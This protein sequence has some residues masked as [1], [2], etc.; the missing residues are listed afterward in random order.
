MMR[1]FALLL[2][3]VAAGSAWGQNASTSPATGCNARN[4]AQAAPAYLAVND[5]CLGSAAAKGDGQIAPSTYSMK[6]GAP[7]LYLN[8]TAQMLV[9]VTDST[10]NGT[11]TISPCIARS[12]WISTTSGT[13]Y[14]IL[15]FGAGA[16]S[17]VSASANSSG[18]NTVTVASGGTNVPIY[19]PVTDTTTPGN[20][21]A[22]TYVTATTATSL[23]LNNNVTVASA[24]IV[25]Y[26][27]TLN[28]Q[29]NSP[30]S[31]CTITISPNPTTAVAGNLQY[32]VLFP[33]GNNGTSATTAISATWNQWRYDQC[34]ISQ[35]TA[36]LVCPAGTFYSLRDLTEGISQNSRTP[37]RTVVAIHDPTGGCA[38]QYAQ[39]LSSDAGGDT[40]TLDRP[41]A[42]AITAANY[43]SIYWGS[44]LF[45]S[46]YR[47]SLTM[48]PGMAIDVP[49]TGTASTGPAPV[50]LLTSVA[51][52][53]DYLSA[54]LTANA[55]ANTPTNPY[56][57]WLRVGTDDTA[58]TLAACA[59]AVSKFGG[60]RGCYWP[61]GINTF[62]ASVGT[63][64]DAVDAFAATQECGEGNIIWPISADWRRH[65]FDCANGPQPYDERM[66]F[67]AQDLR[68]SQ[69]AAAAG[70]VN[71]AIVG[72]SW[73][74][75]GINAITDASNIDGLFRSIVSRQNRAVTVVIDNFTIGGQQTAA[76]DPNGPSYGNGS[77]LPSGSPANFPDFYQTNTAAQWITYP[78]NDANK[79]DLIVSRLGGNDAYSF[80][81]GSFEN[82]INFTQSAAWYTQN[83]KYPDIRIVL[84]GSIPQGATTLAVWRGA[85]LVAGAQRSMLDSGWFNQVMQTSATISYLD[86]DA[87]EH[88]LAEAWDPFD[89]PSRYAMEILPPAPGNFTGS[90]QG[91][92]WYG[93]EPVM[94]FAAGITISQSGS[95]SAA[96]FFSNI[97]NGFC[98]GEGNGAATTPWLAGTQTGAHVPFSGGAIC[99]DYNTGSGNYNINRYLYRTV[100]TNTCALANGG[101]ATLT[102]STA[103]I[104]MG[105]KRGQAY[106]AGAGAAACPAFMGGGST[107]WAG[108]I[109]AGGVSSDGTTVTF[110]ATATTPFSSQPTTV[111]FYRLQPG[112]PVTTGGGLGAA[113][114]GP[115]VVAGGNTTLTFYIYAS[116]DGSAGFSE[117]VNSQFEEGTYRCQWTGKYSGFIEDQYYPSLF[118]EDNI[119]HTVM[120]I[121]TGPASEVNAW[122]QVTQ[123]SRLAAQFTTS[124]EGGPCP[125]YSGF[126]GGACYNHP[127]SIGTLGIYKRVF[128]NADWNF[129]PPQFSS[130]GTSAVSIASGACGAGANGTIS[131]VARAGKITIASAT[132]TACAVGFTPQWPTTLKTCTISPATSAS[133]GS[134]VAAYVS[135]LAA[136]GFTVSGT[137]LASTSFYYNC[138]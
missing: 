138:Q 132:T 55:A 44:S 3:L 113:G 74:Q 111:M 64:A 123:S 120:N 52:V 106:V 11:V 97:A 67:A 110:T 86:A 115:H 41:A 93:T 107:C 20:V 6:S 34:G 76:L 65:T 57:A 10:S 122:E 87:W 1:V 31:G 102:C 100:Q 15:L 94:G 91:F 103:I 14:R 101:V 117:N 61:P 63:G 58:N 27:A 98:L 8:H 5:P 7:G 19:S 30:T 32:L 46:T 85:L 90:N 88:R 130:P 128:E 38:D 83:S 137:A 127:A 77:G 51:S 69:S 16:T 49:G 114:C 82:W 125:N 124:E 135:A 84:G 75:P 21:P 72:D 78:E 33:A 134:G 62:M 71:V 35:G 60:Y 50:D 2:A 24:D 105:F 17:T 18:T 26:A 79:I 59:A 40:A 37:F 89:V 81:E 54:S 29:V 119:A 25:R 96:T 23:T 80:S 99:V 36:A 68:Q 13:V 9:S 39:I 66:A 28:A 121:H 56:G 95:L 133:A 53:T 109:A 136:T 47:G 12:D 131:G 92:P 129:T 48:A 45:S 73:M 70:T 118:T 112:D 126:Y 108:T 43:A 116:A 42:C 104:N 4:L 22:G